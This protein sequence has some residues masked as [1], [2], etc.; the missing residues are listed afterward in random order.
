MLLA[1]CSETS[2][3]APSPSPAV[4]AKTS[5]GSVGPVA[6]TE[7]LTPS[8]FD[9]K[10]DKT[11][12]FGLAQ[13]PVAFNDQVGLD[14]A[15]LTDHSS[16]LIV[17]QLY[18]TLFQFTPASMEAKPGNFVRSVT[19]SPDGLSYALKLFRGIRFSDGSPLDARAIRFNFERWSKEGVYHKGD[20]QTWRNY[21][22]GFPGDILDKAEVD[23]DG[24]S[25]NLKLKRKTASL[26]QILAMPQFGIVSPNSFDK[27]GYFIRPIGSGPYAAE[28]PVR[29][30][31]HYIVLKA[32][33]NYGV[34]RDPK[35]V[36]PPLLNSLVV[37]VLRPSQDGLAELKRGTIS[38][39][40]KLRPEIIPE[41]RNDSSLN[42]LY[43]DSLN[44]AFLTLNQSRPP[45]NQREVREAFAYAINVRG[46]VSKLYNSLGQPAALFLPPTALTAEP[47]ASPYPYD[48]ER[49]KQLMNT[50]GYSSNNP[51]SLDLWVMP[52]PRSYYPDPKKIA[53]AIRSDLAAIGV[54][55][56][57]R[58]DKQWPSFR[59]DRDQGKLTFFMNGWQG[60]HGDPDEFLGYFFGQTKTEDGYDNPALQELVKRGRE[61]TELAERR[62]IY[63]EAQK[64]IVRD[65]AII[66][67]AYV[68]SVVAVR[69]E[70]KGYIAHPSGLES[71]AG[72]SFATK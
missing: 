12:I 49:A 63:Q 66:P 24:I 3:P 22:G 64:L 15:N 18:E 62:A 44:I 40:D 34:E 35:T 32:N 67:L 21:F 38:A 30:E 11:F 19:V 37:T 55:V 65:F 29:G 4:T 48:P 33:P 59:E 20:F 70:I 56:N 45:F 36:P 16:L 58:S 57:I 71:W 43:R 42:L 1:S 47:A 39:T 46:L 8:A 53:E 31:V 5:T 10:T 13:E 27:D 2:Q 51:L 69:P 72:V 17:R 68:Q 50:A 26:Y 60:N 9:F 61:A 6:I 41:A 28:K 52:V 54:T 14:P 25:L 7:N 23:E